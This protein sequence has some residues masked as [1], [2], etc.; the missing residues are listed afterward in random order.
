[1]LS[2]NTRPLQVVF[3]AT[4]ALSFHMLL[5]AVFEIASVWP[6]GARFALWRVDLTGLAMLQVGVVP[7]LL[8]FSLLQ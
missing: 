1:M 3:S 5:L 8:A 4:F 7:G 6:M 2:V